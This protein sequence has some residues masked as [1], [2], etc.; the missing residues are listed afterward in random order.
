[1]NSDPWF[2]CPQPNPTAETR[3]F[4]FPYAGG[5]PSA[6]HQWRKEFPD[7][8]ETQIIHYPGRGSRH[9]DPPIKKLSVMIEEIVKAI[10]P[11]LDKPFTFFGHS[12]GGLIAFELT[13]SLRRLN[14]PRPTQLFI[15]ACAAPHLPNPNPLIHTLPDDKFLE[16]LKALNGIPSE[17]LQ[18]PE[19][20][21]LLLPILRADFELVETYQF[22]SA[23]P[24]DPPIAAFGGL[25]DPR[26]SREQL[27]GWAVHTTSNFESKFFDGNHFFIN[28]PNGVVIRSIVAK[29]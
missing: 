14:L 28:S 17:V 23:P 20:L 2:A 29:L 4:I 22:E 9:N 3:L 10:Q 7:T 24:L 13:R 6:F 15:S 25:A 16:S 8:I 18:H 27:E 12:L 26:V 5:G 19:L 11:L 1:M 21:Q